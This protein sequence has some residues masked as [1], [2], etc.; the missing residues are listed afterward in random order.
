MPA[1]TR[2]AEPNVK[3][4]ILIVDDYVIIQE[5]VT[6]LLEKSGFIVLGAASQGAEAIQMAAELRPAVAL[7]D[8]SMPLLAGINTA[9]GVQGS[10]PLTKRIMVADEATLPSAPAGMAGYIT[11]RNASDLVEAIRQDERSNEPQ[12]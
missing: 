11:K 3:T 7:L 8:L 10:S 4:G 6:A 12:Y 1:T 2:Q 9:L 5:S